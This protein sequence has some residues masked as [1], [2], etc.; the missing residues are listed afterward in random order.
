MRAKPIVGEEM[1]R[2]CLALVKRSVA[3]PK[4]TQ[5]QLEEQAEQSVR[6]DDDNVFSSPLP[7]YIYCPSF[8]FTQQQPPPSPPFL[9]PASITD[10]FNYRGRTY[11]MKM[12]ILF[13]RFPT[14][15]RFG[16]LTIAIFIG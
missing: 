9:S 2:E 6:S 3:P 11:I 1:L 13:S 14:K 12:K 8:H 10:H 4:P 5:E 16:P 15:F 7:S